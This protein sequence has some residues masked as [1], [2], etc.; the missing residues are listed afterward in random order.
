LARASTRIAVEQC[1]TLVG[2]RQ[3]RIW[4]ARKLRRQ[5]GQPTQ[6]E[7]DGPWVLRREERHG[8]VVGFYHTH[9]GMPALLS[10]RDVRTMRAWCSAF[11]KPLLCL[12]DGMEG[13]RGYLVADDESAGKEIAVAVFRRGIIVAV[14]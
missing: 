8:D 7:F 4:C 12:I 2:E 1:W 3:G 10:N 5:S 13:V 11:G 6:V 14:R 9:P